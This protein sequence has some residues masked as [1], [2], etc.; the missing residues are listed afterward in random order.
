MI[1]PKALALGVQLI[2]PVADGD[3][4]PQLNVEPVCKGI[5]EQ[6]GVTFRDPSVAQEK[7]T[8]L[9][10]SRPCASRS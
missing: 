9:K 10:A 2:M 1:L 3:R 5:A 8:A 7:R 4:V 6:G